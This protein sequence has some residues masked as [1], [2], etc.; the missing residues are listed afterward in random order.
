MSFFTLCHADDAPSETL[1]PVASS[2]FTKFRDP[3]RA[4]LVLSFLKEN[5]FT[6]NQLQKLVIYRVGL[7]IKSRLK[8][9]QE[10]GLSSEEIAK[11]I[12]SNQAILHSSTENKI[13]PSLSMLKGLLGS[14][15]DVARLVK[16]C[17]WIF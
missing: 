10:L 2:R 9:F 17:P 7:L 1:I 12:S 11:M 3:Q 6:T 4:D 16:R 14:N 15:D 13:I 8:V 5:S